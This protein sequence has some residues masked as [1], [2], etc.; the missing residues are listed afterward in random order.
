MTNEL[1]DAVAGYMKADRER[2]SDALLSCFSQDAEVTDEDRTYT[3]HAE[4]RQW[5]EGAA[6]A[7]EYTVEV[8][9]SEPAGPD[10]HIV[11]AR[12]E[13]NFPGGTANLTYRFIL[14]DG[15]IKKLE[16]AP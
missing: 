4:I 10:G 1:P 12:L 7:Y 16:I 8:L 13:G 9:S 6:A 11:R 15:L 2:D 5:R 3:G 14:L